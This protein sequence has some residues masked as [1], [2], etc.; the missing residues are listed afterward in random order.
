MNGYYDFLRTATP[1]VRAHQGRLFVVKLGGEMLEDQQT[2]GHILEQLSLLQHLG[3][4]V[5]IV[6]GGA[7]QIA[8]LCSRLDLPVDMQLGRRVTS[9][10]VLEAVSM[11]LCGSMQADITAS[12]AALGVRAVGISGADAGL[13]LASRRAPVDDGRG[14]TIDYGEVG[15]IVEMDCTLVNLLCDAGY[16]PVL[17]PLASDGQG[18]LLNIN[19]DTVAARLA[20]ETQAAKLIFMMGPAGILADPADPGSLI[21]EIDTAGLL[22]LEQSGVFS[23]GMLPKSAAARSAIAAGVERVHFVSGLGRDALLREI[24][25]NEGSGTMVLGNA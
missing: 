21:P 10:A 1:Y 7:P 11:T 13:L 25:T 23:A 9:P 8:R 22:A 5:A 3:I 17:A 19:A 16:L 4:K 12:L 18:G 24:F 6:H 20:V 2:A 15:D 14:G